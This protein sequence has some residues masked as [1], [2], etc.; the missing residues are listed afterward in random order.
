VARKDDVVWYLSVEQTEADGVTTIAAEGRIS[1]RTSR[2]LQRILDAATESLRQDVVLD[3]T[4]VDYISSAGLRTLE[5]TAD[6]LGATGRALV[7][8]SL[9][10]SVKA[11]LTLAGPIPHLAVEPARDSAIERVRD[12]RRRRDA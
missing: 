4:G 3:L 1:E 5:R 2:D 10:E 8:C 11:A 9:Q 7:V 6:R 12:A